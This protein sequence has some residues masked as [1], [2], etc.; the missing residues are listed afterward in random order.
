MEKLP[1]NR[2]GICGWERGK[3]L[4]CA[5]WIWS[6]SVTPWEHLLCLSAFQGPEHHKGPEGHTRKSGLL[7]CKGYVEV[8]VSYGKV[9]FPFV[10]GR[11]EEQ[12]WKVTA[13]WEGH[14]TRSHV[15]D[16]S[17]LTQQQLL[18]FNTGFSW[19]PGPSVPP[20]PPPW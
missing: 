6:L 2:A 15:Q 12:D 7:I 17:L 20:Y 11:G 10:G 3:S 19:L 9:S 16:S 1:S 13:L 5:Y 4:K 8:G 14:I 18:H